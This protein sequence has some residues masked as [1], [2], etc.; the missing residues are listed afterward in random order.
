MADDAGV[1][2]GVDFHGD[3]IGKRAHPLPTQ[4]IGR[5]ETRL[6]ARFGKILDDSKRL[7]Q[8]VPVDRQGRHEA[9]RVAGAVF[10]GTLLTGQEINGFAP[11][12]QAEAF[13]RDAHTVAGG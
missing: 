3:R 2:D 13:E 8:D 6:G 4:R 10:R 5:Q 11:V 9:L 12:G 1:A 7:R